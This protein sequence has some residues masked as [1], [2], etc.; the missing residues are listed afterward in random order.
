MK[1]RLDVERAD[2]EA[3]RHALEMEKA[4]EAAAAIKR[5][6]H[7]DPV[8]VFSWTF[9]TSTWDLTSPGRCHLKTGGRK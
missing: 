4:R 1:E 8:K 5:K 7:Q 6:G 2:R 9:A 3:A